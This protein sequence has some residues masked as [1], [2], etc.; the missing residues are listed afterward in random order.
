MLINLHLKGKRMKT[1]FKNGFL[2]DFEKPLNV[3][4][5]VKDGVIE[6]IGDLSKEKADKIVDLKG[7]IVSPAFANCFYRSV[8]AVKN[9]YFSEDKEFNAKEK[10]IIKKY[11]KVKNILSGSLYFQDFSFETPY[12]F[13]EKIN[14]KEEKEL[15]NISLSLKDSVFIKIGQSLEEMGEINSNS[16]KMPSEF[17]EDFG[18]LDKKSVIIGG[19]LFEKDELEIFSSYN[20]SFVLL[21]NDDARSGR[22]YANINSLNKF[23]IPFGIG[24]GDFA[25]IDFFSFMRQILSFN[26]FVME[27]TSLLSPKEAYKIATLIGAK[28]IGYDAKVSEGNFANFIVLNSKNILNR[29]IFKGIVFEL[30]KQDVIMTVKEGKILQENGVFVMENGEVYD[31]IYL[32]RNLKK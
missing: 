20:S 1:L 19:N 25:E 18:F 12:S 32:E 24:S 17:L 23:H 14:E 5:L 16:K 22:R 4:I 31:K 13:V 3:D 15:E 29:D 6:K 11:M 7:D 26:S 28:I 30:S 2:I 27:N 10:E 8:E 9:S 21:P